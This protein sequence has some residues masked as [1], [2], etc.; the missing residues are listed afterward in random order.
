MQAATCP[1]L[2]EKRNEG[3]RADARERRE[4]ASERAGCGGGGGGGRG[5]AAATV[6]PE[7]AGRLA[8]PL[9]GWMS[10]SKSEGGL[11]RQRQQPGRGKSSAPPETKVS[12]R[13][14]AGCDLPSTSSGQLKLWCCCCWGLWTTEF[15]GHLLWIGTECLCS[16]EEA[17]RRHHRAA[18][19]V[20]SL[21]A[22]FS[23]D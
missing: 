10:S 7:Q 11:P 8:P 9:F 17:V 13:R 20:K 21:T 2:E 12:S 1:L 3:R 16:G 22:A 15:F 6:L 14:P 4:G 23:P 18:A 19:G 5:A